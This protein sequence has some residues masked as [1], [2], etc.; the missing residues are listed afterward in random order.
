MSY[1]AASVFE[2]FEI[3]KWVDLEI[4][5]LI[6]LS[7]TNA[8]I[9][10]LISVLVYWSMFRA[11]GLEEG[12]LVPSRLQ[13][14]LEMIEDGIKAMVRENIGGP[15]KADKYVGFILAIFMFILIQNMIGLIPYTFSP[16]AQIAVTFGLSLSIWIGVTLLGFINNGSHY[17]SMFMPGGSPLVLAPFMVTLEL[18]SHTAK[19]VSLGVRLAANITA[20]HILF[21]ILAGFIWKMWMAGGFI[22]VGSVIPVFIL[23][24]VTVIEIGVAV[25]QAYVFSLLTTIYTSE[26]IDT[27]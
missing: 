23:T 16:T 9:F 10:M 27:H 13:S 26:G 14:S 3:T 6:D 25:I 21:V 17:L 18:I 2:Q 24:V 4:E 5:G 1:I 8:T 7:I 19:A 11:S 20:G 12:K 22:A 15:A